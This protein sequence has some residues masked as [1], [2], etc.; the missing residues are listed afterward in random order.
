VH[1]DLYQVT[2]N[3]CDFF[4]RLATYSNFYVDIGTLISNSN[5]SNQKSKKLKLSLSHLTQTS[6]PNLKNES[7]NDSDIMMRLTNFSEVPTQ[8]F[9]SITYSH[10]VLIV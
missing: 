10:L 1:D 5:V 4:I 2:I 6:K 9:A 8:I 3:V 7:R